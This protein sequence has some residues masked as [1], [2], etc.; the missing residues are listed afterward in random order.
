MRKSKSKHRRSRNSFA[1][2]AA[3]E[4]ADVHLEPWLRKAGSPVEKQTRKKVVRALTKS[5]AKPSTD[6]AGLTAMLV[7]PAAGFVPMRDTGS[8]REVLWEHRG[9]KLLGSSSVM[10][11]IV[12]SRS[13]P[14]SAS[15]TRYSSRP[16]TAIPTN[17][18]LESANAARRALVGP[19]SYVQPAGIFAAAPRLRP[20][21]GNDAARRPRPS[22]SRARP[23]HEFELQ[24][25]DFPRLHFLG[26][27]HP[28]RPSSAPPARQ[29][30][31]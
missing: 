6:N 20:A 30:G 7:L 3:G 19:A 5:R 28:W 10:S 21:S 11:D 29:R 26:S 24:S 14:S 15:T 8:K 27:P 13:R 22:S 9:G 4:Q 1:D 18:V 16:Q 23:I 25:A 2:S 31:T 12:K 17:R